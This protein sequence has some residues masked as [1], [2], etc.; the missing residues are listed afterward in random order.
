MNFLQR[1]IEDPVRFARIKRWCIVGLVV[2]VLLEIAQLIFQGGHPHFWF[3]KL[4]AWGSIY[5]LVSCAAIIIVSKLIG[6]AWLMRSE[7]YYDD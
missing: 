2:V 4:P 1:Q 3:E 5:G 7:D 6:K